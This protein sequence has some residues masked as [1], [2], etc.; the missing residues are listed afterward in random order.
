MDQVGHRWKLLCL[1]PF[2]QY[3]ILNAR[4]QSVA[5]ISLGVGD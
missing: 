4:A 3:G 2:D 1:Q 5:R